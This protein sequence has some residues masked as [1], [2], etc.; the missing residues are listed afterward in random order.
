MA[1]LKIHRQEEVRNFCLH[2]IS[3]VELTEQRITLAL[4][5]RECFWFKL[6][7]T[8]FKVKHSGLPA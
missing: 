3:T 7:A 8:T 1:E 4:T 5:V 2:D 6:A